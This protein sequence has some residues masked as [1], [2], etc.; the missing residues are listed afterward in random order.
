MQQLAE[1]L[2]QDR[3]E[4]RQRANQSL[5]NI[6]TRAQ[7]EVPAWSVALQ[8]EQPEDRER[9]VQALSDSTRFS[10]AAFVALTKGGS[11]PGGDLEMAVGAG[12]LAAAIGDGQEDIRY[13]AVAA[14]RETNK[15]VNDAWIALEQAPK[16]DPTAR[17]TINQALKTIDDYTSMAVTAL[18]AAAKD[19]NVEVQRSAVQAMGELRRQGGEGIPALVDS[20]KSGP[21]EVRPEA[22]LALG[23]IGADPTG[24]RENRG[25]IVPTL[26]E[27]L[28]DPDP[29]VR[30]RA[31][32]ALGLLGGKADT[33]EPKLRAL[34]GDD[35]IVLRRQAAQALESIDPEH[36]V[37]RVEQ[38]DAETEQEVAA[39]LLA[40]KGES[41]A[42]RSEAVRTLSNLGSTAMAALPD[43]AA[44][45][46]SSPPEGRRRIA[47]SLQDVSARALAETPRLIRD[48]KGRG[49]AADRAARALGDLGENAN[50]AQPDLLE[51]LNDPDPEVRLTVAEVLADISRSMSAV[52]GALLVESLKN[53]GDAISA[54]RRVSGMGAS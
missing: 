5:A 41:P 7:A 52:V 18:L 42:T 9:A 48:L 23:Q 30:Y 15:E 51:A 47:E 21:D 35:D 4:L 8:Q 49:A 20:V 37:G 24:T 11:A 26:T 13:A 6:G 3:A 28:D 45:L 46:T 34:L 17:R 40:V 19:D 39:L 16:Y 53:D 2:Q 12:P 44:R 32:E 54:L 22:A 27:A 33:A 31:A 50:L 29:N 10:S 14:L 43:L 36:E 1:R 25:L 38:V